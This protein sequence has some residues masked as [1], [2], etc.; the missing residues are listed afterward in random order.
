VFVP[1]R[2]AAAPDRGGVPILRESTAP[3]NASNGQ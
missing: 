1:S 2:P 3:E